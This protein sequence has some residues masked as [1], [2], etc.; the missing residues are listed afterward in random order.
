MQMGIR[1][2]E[3]RFNASPDFVVQPTVVTQAHTHRRQQS[4]QQP[5]LKGKPAGTGEIANHAGVLLSWLTM[6]AELQLL[7]R[8]VGNLCGAATS[9]R[10]MGRV[11]YGRPTSRVKAGP[12]EPARSLGAN[13]SLFSFAQSL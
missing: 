8:S 7:A 9:A 10:K 3:F 5:P 12:C 2:C 6:S 4:S 11:W 1:C 13:R